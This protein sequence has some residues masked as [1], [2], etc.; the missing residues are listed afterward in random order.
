VIEWSE[1][2]Q[3]VILCEGYHDRN[4]WSG[5]L[6][7]AG[8]IDPGI[9][10]DRAARV[11]FK[12]P[13][14]DTVAGKGQF[15]LASPS[16]GFVRVQPCHGLSNVLPALDVL[17]SGLESR[18]TIRIVLVVDPDTDASE[19]MGGL[20]IDGV[21]QFVTSRRPAAS[22]NQDG[23]ISLPESETLISLIRW[24]CDD[25]QAP[26]LPA[27]QTLE[28][29]ISASIA[30]AYPERAICVEGWLT[31]RHEPP[32][33]CGKEYSWSYMAGWYAENGCD[34][35]MRAIWSDGKVAQAMENRLRASGAW[36]IIEQLA[37]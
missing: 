6:Q 34:D 7:S 24:E 8:C 28:R 31:N 9:D 2:S 12:D 15:G 23:D 35:F 22:L 25:P 37:K 19:A 11:L 32:E 21:L 20:T 3:S 36:R 4:F 27:Q 13:F 30:E 5:L 16:N 33:L 1:K 29:L 18:R 14:G 10:P 17:L 26:G